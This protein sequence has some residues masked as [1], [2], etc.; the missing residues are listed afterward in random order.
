[1]EDTGSTGSATS[2]A[3]APLSSHGDIVQALSSGAAAQTASVP[4]TPNAPATPGGP[5]APAASPA[6][7]P[8]SPDPRTPPI[9]AA[10][11]PDADLST[12]P[13]GPIPVDRHK[14]I[15]ER[16]REKVAQETRAAFE[17]EHG[18]WLQL[19][20]EFTPDEF[21]T[22]VPTLKDLTSHPQRFLQ[23]LAGELGYQLVPNGQ[24][25]AAR[26]APTGASS[27]APTEQPQPD[28]AVQLEN[29]QIAH[30]YSAEQQ[31]RRDQWLLSQ[32]QGNVTKEL[33]P[34][35]DQQ[36]QQ[37][38]QAFLGRI[39]ARARADFAEVAEMEG[40]NELRPK[41]AEIMTNDKRYGLQGA[42][43]RAYKEHYLPTRDT[44]IRQAVVDEL[45][46]KGRA[47][48][49]SLSPTRRT[50]AD[51]GPTSPRTTADILREKAAE[52]GVTF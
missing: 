14:K 46:Q 34:F 6:V 23:N 22:L 13:V 44:K 28:I 42:Y 32:I 17:Q 18:P 41:I 21:S 20:R 11:D 8:G 49:S 36:Q 50:T 52:F 47:A 51:S 37:E 39:D 33:Q 7:P 30:T 35:R 24:N 12:P 3:P 2:A 15:L 19:K 26:P 16:T 5:A 25:G 31:A 27:P 9:A 1:V 43:L 38:H 4:P 45:N 48:T 10:P 40:F 29:G